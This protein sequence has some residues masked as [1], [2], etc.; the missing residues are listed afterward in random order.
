MSTIPA[1]TVKHAGANEGDILLGVSPANHGVAIQILASQSKGDGGR[2]RGPF[3]LLHPG[4]GHYAA[5]I[6]ALL[7][8][9]QFQT[10]DEFLRALQRAPG[11]ER[12]THILNANMLR[13]ASVQEAAEVQ[14][15][16]PQSPE[17][18]SVYGGSGDAPAPAAAAQEQWVSPDE[19]V[20]PPPLVEGAVCRVTV[21]AYERNPE[22]R[23]RCIDA[24]GT[25]CCICGFSFGSVYGAVA[26]GYIHVHHL[27]P[28]SDIRAEYVV[29]PVEDLRPVCPNCH[30]VL[31]LGG[32]CRS[33]DDVRRLL[34]R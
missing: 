16:H 6:G 18:K 5:G 8:Q 26:Q 15:R 19:V 24:H 30:A 7:Q 31:H 25:A 11:C 27:R 10:A 20:G 1:D 29:D 17:R 14:A 2:I 33:I 4:Q 23:Q 3:I 13:R 21:N 22:A 28:L 9:R 32:E 34:G 12:A